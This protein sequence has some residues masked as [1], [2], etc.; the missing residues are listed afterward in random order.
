VGDPYKAMA[1]KDL[2][3]VFTS[4]QLLNILLCINQ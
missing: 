4:I 1:K 3:C 2:Q